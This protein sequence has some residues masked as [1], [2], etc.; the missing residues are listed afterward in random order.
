MLSAPSPPL[1]AAGGT[2]RPKAVLLD[3]NQTLFPLEPLRQ[4]FRE[5]GL[6]GPQDLE[7]S[8]PECHIRRHVLVQFT[9]IASPASQCERAAWA[10]SLALY[11]RTRASPLTAALVGDCC[12]TLVGDCCLTLSHDVPSADAALVLL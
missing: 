12:L 4:R 10:S 8:H 1:P 9:A 11:P 6:H 7:V 2:I 5:V 3:V